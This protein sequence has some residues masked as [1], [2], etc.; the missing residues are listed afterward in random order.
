MRSAA[1]RA[2][3][4]LIVAVDSAEALS[5]FLPGIIMG[6]G[7]ALSTGVWVCACGCEGRG[8]WRG[9]REELKC[10][11]Y[12][13]AVAHGPVVGV[14][15]ACVAGMHGAVSVETM[16]G[17]AFVE[18]MHGAVS[19]ETMHGSAFVETMHGAVSVET[20]HGSAFVET[21]PVCFEGVCMHAG[22]QHGGMVAQ[23]GGAAGS[24]ALVEAL[25]ALTSA[26]RSTLSDDSLP[27]RVAAVGGEGSSGAGNGTAAAAAAWEEDGGAGGGGQGA[28]QGVASVQSAMQ[29]LQLLSQRAK[30]GGSNASGSQGAAASGE[31]G[32]PGAHPPP[33]MRQLAASSAAGAA[34]GRELRVERTQEWV[35]FTSDKVH[36]VLGASLAPLTQHPQPAVREALAE[37]EC[38]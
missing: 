33:A 18:T 12:C 17:S 3:R 1:L 34:G 26:L 11:R 19:V 35:A 31:T 30:R 23:T 15:F 20:M 6:L 8:G 36:E 37:S 21:S 24:S 4:S 10:S 16:H 7:R 38:V 9:G 28:G 25:R 5:F 27:S 32:R 29:Q 22:Q 14:L 13:N 2:L